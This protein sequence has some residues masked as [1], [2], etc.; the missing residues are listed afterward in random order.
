LLIVNIVG[1]PV[2]WPGRM[3]LYLGVLSFQ[4]QTQWYELVLM[5]IYHL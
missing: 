5:S 1:R 2:F 3:T 4:S